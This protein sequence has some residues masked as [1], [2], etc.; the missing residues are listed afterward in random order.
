MNNIT[1]KSKNIKENK[2]STILKKYL[3][4]ENNLETQAL[5]NSFGKM[6]NAR[7][8]TNPKYSFGKEERFPNSK[9]K[10]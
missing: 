5:R 6:V 2:E 9:N 3:I 1:E 8:I 10:K 7:N 4:Y